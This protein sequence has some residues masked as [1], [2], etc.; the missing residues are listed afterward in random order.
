MLDVGEPAKQYLALG[1]LVTE[2]VR[3]SSG[4]T[5]R[6]RKGKATNG[7]SDE[8]GS[9]HDR[10]PSEEGKSLQFE[11]ARI[12]VEHLLGVWLHAAMS[13]LKRRSGSSPEAG[14]PG[15]PAGP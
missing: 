4:T 10:R 11:E 3:C 8:T 13:T 12:R 2:S 1:A 7:S 5:A 14:R 15:A 6:V 9:G